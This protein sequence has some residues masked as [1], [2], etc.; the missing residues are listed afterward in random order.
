[1][2]IPSHFQTESSLQKNRPVMRLSCFAL[3]GLILAMAAAGCATHSQNWLEGPPEA[4]GPALTDELALS[5]AESAVDLAAA[6]EALESDAGARPEEL[7]F[8][9]ARPDHIAPD[10]GAEPAAASAAGDEKVAASTPDAEP[11]AD[12]DAAFPADSVLAEVNGEA[13]TLQ[14]ALEPVQA[15][16]NRWRKEC[17][18]EEFQRRC[19]ALAEVRARETVIH[20]LLVQEAKA[21]LSAEEQGR[22]K[23]VVAETGAA[24]LTEIVGSNSDPVSKTVKMQAEE[25]VLV[26]GY[27]REKLAPQV[28][29]TQSE[30]LAAYRQAMA[31]RYVLP[32]KV[33]MG[34]IAIRKSDS[35]TPAWAESVATAVQSRAAHGEDFATLAQKYARDPAA[36]ADGDWGFIARGASRLPAV[37]EVLFGLKVS[38]V[39]PVVETRDT[40]YII[41]VLDREEGRTIPFAEVQASLEQELRDKQYKRL[42]AGYLRDLYD[43]WSGQFKTATLTTTPVAAAD[44]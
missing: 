17:S 44:R 4:Q 29:V 16:V 12:Q 30:L 35:A 32:T 27:L 25:W 40:F 22:L 42:V 14:A 38:Q 9:V 15:D 23:A 3:A 31:D 2:L 5:P 37:E 6:P 41:K 19:R 43:Q 18:A 36:P 28:R 10:S 39:G 11:A 1:M 26:Q 34:M 7:R 21:Q 20:R 24:T 13:I 8:V 33:R